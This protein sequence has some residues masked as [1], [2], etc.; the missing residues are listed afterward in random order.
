[1][2]EFQKQKALEV[3][4]LL[5]GDGVDALILFPGANIAYYTGFSIGL[6]ERLAAALI[7]VN[8]EP[9]FIVN[10]LEE[11]LRGQRPWFNNVAVWREHEDSVK[12]LADTL[13]EKRLLSSRIGIPEEAPWGWVNRLKGMLPDA[14]FVDV[15]GHLGYGRMVKNDQELEW[16]RMACVIA[17]KAMQ[18]G[19][20]GL[21]TGMTE[22][23]LQGVIVSEMKKM[24]S[25]QTFCGVLFGERGALPHG[26]AGDTRLEPGMGILI[27]MGA[28]VHGYWSD[29]TRTVFYGEPTR[30]QREIYGI[31]YEANQAA[32]KAIR[33]GV[34][35][36][37]VDVAARKVVEDAGYGEYFIHRLGHGVGMQVHEHPY[38][39]RNNRQL[40]EAGMVFSNEPGIYIVGEI[41]V[42]VEDTVV[43]TPE[44]AESLTRHKRTL[45]S[46]PVRD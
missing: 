22:R 13:R 8:G 27:D 10:E 37:S 34:T 17:D 29:L 36:E 32:F 43:C 5:E 26:H 2:S 19:W 24:G 39:V 21:H 31:V 44:G 12:L 35:C 20:E 25:S 1:M 16:I 3:L 6:S 18:V 38:I 46:Y 28:N 14:E 41:G 45:T 33:P 23:E 9:L 4:E 40:L 42:R 7:P 30:R 11:E 15:S